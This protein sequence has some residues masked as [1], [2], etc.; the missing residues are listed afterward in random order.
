MALLLG[1]CHQTVKCGDFC[2]NFSSDL[3]AYIKFYLQS[4][5]FSQ[6]KLMLPDQ[7]T[8]ASDHALEKAYSRM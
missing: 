4:F 8:V 7:K 1:I 2:G 6:M 3:S 5:F